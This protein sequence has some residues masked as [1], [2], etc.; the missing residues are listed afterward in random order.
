MVGVLA[1]RGHMHTLLCDLREY[2]GPRAVIELLIEGPRG[3]AKSLNFT[4]FLYLTACKFPGMR[5][6]VVRKTRADLAATWCQT[7]ESEVLPPQ[8]RP[9][10][11]G[12]AKATNRT[13]YLL[14]N[15]SVFYLVGLDRPSKH[16]GANLDAVIIEEAEEVRWDQVQG[17]FGAIRQFTDGLPWQLFACLTNPGPPKHWANKR[18]NK[19]LMRRVVTVHKDNPKWWDR[20]SLSWTEEGDAYMA[21]LSHYTGVQYKRHVLGEWSGMEGLVLQDFDEDLHII[22]HPVDTNGKPTLAPLDLRWFFASKD[23]GTTAPGCLA[24]WGVDGDGRMFCVAEWYMTGKT[25]DWWCDR[26]VEADEEFD[27]RAGVA[28]PSRNDAIKS[29]N[30]AVASRRGA[31]LCSIFRGADNRRASSGV[32]DFSGIDLIRQR[33]RPAVDGKPRIFWLHDYLRHMPD[34]ELVANGRPTCTTDELPELIYKPVDDG[35]RNMEYTDPS[36]ADHGFDQM[37][38]AAS[39]AQVRDLSDDPVERRARVGSI[40]SQLRSRNSEAMDEWLDID[41]DREAAAER[42]KEMAR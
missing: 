26:A 32:G 25:L 27:L 42:E 19:G 5:I 8:V 15:G 20:R 35:Q 39:F 10:V 28:D 41:S 11:V 14:P 12:D 37:R 29:F 1:P 9:I 40:A 4:R 21:S 7:F 22:Q 30:Q 31:K 6:L 17:F 34:P 2:S 3:S 38:Y 23:W 36:R 24:V 18:A 13:E 33:L 16:Q